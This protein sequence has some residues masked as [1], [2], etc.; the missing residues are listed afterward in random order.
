MAPAA[1]LLATAL[2]YGPLQP[3]IA[4]A[5]A[6]LRP[7]DLSVRPDPSRLDVAGLALGAERAA[8]VLPPPCIADVCQP[9][10]AVPGFEPR[11][12]RARRSEVFLHV[13]QRANVEPLA[14]LT[15][16]VI[17]TGLRLEWSPPVFSY[18]QDVNARGWGTVMLRLRVRMDAE[19][20][21][22]FPRRPPS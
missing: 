14:S 13:L 8:E 16:A 22:I 6:V 12:D 15:W 2:L 18:G 7:V 19:N 10:V 17:S 21:L 20:R 4:R 1:A 3:P 5:T 9:I 11:F